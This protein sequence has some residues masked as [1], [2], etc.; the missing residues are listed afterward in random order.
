MAGR[1]PGASCYKVQR[2]PVDRSRSS[3]CRLAA[4]EISPELVSAVTDAVL[5][6]VA[7][8]QARPLEPVYAIAFFECLRIKIRDE[9]AVKNKA[10]LADR[11]CVGFAPARSAIATRLAPIVER[12][13]LAASN[14]TQSVSTQALV[15]LGAWLPGAVKVEESDHRYRLLLRARP[16]RCR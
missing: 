5:D 8:W 12:Q 6:E 11:G 13:R 2:E 4:F 14:L 9:G 1:S 7:A 15:K 10:V 16:E 3:R